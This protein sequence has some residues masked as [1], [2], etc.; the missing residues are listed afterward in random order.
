M[1][2]WLWNNLG[3]L[4]L[5]FIL[6]LAVWVVAITNADPTETRELGPIPIDYS[7]LRQ[8]LLIV[9]EAPPI[10]G[11]IT[12]R[13]PLSIWEQIGLDNVG[14]A[15]YLES[16][17]EG[18][19][20]LAVETRLDARPAQVSDWEP[21]S[22]TLTLERAATASLDI[23]VEAVGE[24]QLGFRTT[25]VT[26]SPKRTVILGPL[27]LIDRVVSVVA[28][29]NLLERR[30]DF[31]LEVPLAA[32]DGDGNIIEGIELDPAVAQVT[33]KI[34]PRE[35]FRLVS[36]VPN[37]EGE[38]LL[39]EAGYRL[40]DVSVTPEVMT[41]FSSDPAALQGLPGFVLTSPFNLIGAIGDLERRLSLNLP[42]G[43]SPVEDQGVLV[44]VSISPVEG[45]ITV[46]R[47]V[48]VRGLTDGLFAQLSPESVNI[49]LNG[50][51]PTLN[52]LQ[53]EDVRVILDLLDLGL[54]VYQVTPLV[55]IAPTDVEREPV[56]PS[57]I[58]V[59]LTTEPPPTPTPPP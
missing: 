50:P 43:V 31:D 1:L 36:V 45:T 13:A 33:V 44:K 3:S 53:P 58:E 20:E 2:R 37:L 55:I 46:S 34:E 49:I 35:R 24:P 52:T 38:E 7:G 26:S 19:H 23:T 17:E 22:I 6:A 15:V 59:T 42:Q 5:A 29:V 47:L 11:S 10:T 12:V 16:L 4:L 56:F 14:L 27:S 21:E 39:A 57:T 41:V 8:G 51:L 28:A 30:E 18:T 48:E 54:G 40:T 9:G 25:L 32:V